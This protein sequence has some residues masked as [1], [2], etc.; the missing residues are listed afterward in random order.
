M[1]GI[2]DNPQLRER[3][4]V[5]TDRQDGGKQLGMFTRSHLK[6]PHPVVAAIP[7]G[8]IPVGKGVA[9]GLGAP[10]ELGVV[11]KI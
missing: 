6:Y 10:F 4:F 5:F 8:G 7:A 1:G 9:L 2:L 3:R 11:R